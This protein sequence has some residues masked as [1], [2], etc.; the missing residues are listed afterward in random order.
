MVPDSKYI[1]VSGV[2]I[3]V[4]RQFD[5]ITVWYEDILIPEAIVC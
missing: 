1:E 5:R 4:Q 3:N 2:G